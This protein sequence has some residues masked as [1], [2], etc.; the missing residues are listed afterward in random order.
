MKHLLLVEDDRSMAQKMTGFLEGEGFQITLAS[1]IEEANSLFDQSI[2]LALV[3]WMLPDGDGIELVKKWKATQPSFPV[4]MVTAKASVVDKVVGL[5]IGSNDYITKPFDPIEL[6]ARIKNQFRQRE[7]YQD[8]PLQKC[9]NLAGI[10]INFKEHKTC[11]KGSEVSLTRKQFSLLHLLL[12][13]PGQVFTR[14]E[15][16]NKVWGY[17]KYP[18][19]RTVDNHVAQLR[20]KFS[21]ELFETVHGVGYRFTGGTLET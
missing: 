12:A 3:D 16:L 2:D 18:T 13:S 7:S 8:K 11:F 15:L 19:T 9:I 6:I 14:D 20:C 10:E 17:E 1:S 4:I 5:E 21:A